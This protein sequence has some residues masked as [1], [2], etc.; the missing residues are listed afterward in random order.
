MI[1]THRI[2]FHPPHG[3]SALVSSIYRWLLHGSISFKLSAVAVHPVNLPL[4]PD[5]STAV[6]NSLSNPRNQHGQF[7]L[8]GKHNIII[9]TSISKQHLSSA[10]QKQLFF[11]F[12]YRRYRCRL[13]VK[14]KCRTP[15]SKR[16]LNPLR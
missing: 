9:S 13:N 5:K 2:T 1:K 12:I 16:L 4:K 3:F 7:E 14:Y 8:F 6:L 15:L 11:S 10:N